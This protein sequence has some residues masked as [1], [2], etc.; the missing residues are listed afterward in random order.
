M[1]FER[2]FISI[3]DLEAREGT[4]SWRGVVKAFQLIDWFRQLLGR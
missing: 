4:S 1:A 2:L 3:F